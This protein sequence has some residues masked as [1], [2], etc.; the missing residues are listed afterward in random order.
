MFASRRSLYVLV[1]VIPALV[2][3]A[4]LISMGNTAGYTSG[5]FL[6]AILLIDADYRLMYLARRGYEK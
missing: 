1:V 5:I 6:L 2:V 3:S 4:I